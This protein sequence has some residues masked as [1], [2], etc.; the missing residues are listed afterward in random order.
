[1]KQ[2][3]LLLLFLALG[4]SFQLAAQSVPEAFSYQCIMR[5]ANG[6]ALSN[7]TVTLLF[8]I[9]SGAPNG[10]VAYSEKQTVTTNEF[11]LINTGVGLGTPLQGNFSTINWGGGAKYLSASV[12]SSPNVFDE[13]GATQLLS[14][15]YAIY[16]REASIGPPSPGD[17]WGTQTVQT[18]P[19]LSGNGTLASPLSI[20]Q[21]SATTGQVLKW[22]GSKWAPKNDSI[23]GGGSGSGSV[24]QINTG[25]GLTGGP[26]T[27]AGTIALTNTG[28]TPGVYGSATEIPVITVDAQGRV[29]GIFKTIVQPGAIGLNAGTGINVQTNSFNN[30][31][32]T[33]TGDTNA[34]DDITTSSTADGDVSGPFSNLQLKAGVVGSSE[35]ADGAVTSG[36]IA[37]DAV[38]SAKIADNAVGS[39]QIADNAVSTSELATGAVTSTKIDDMGAATGQVLKYNGTNWV[40]GTDISGGGGGGDNWGTQTVVTG[41]ALT[42]QGIAGSPLNL[43]PQGATSGQVL[44]WNGTAWT[45]GTDNTGAATTVSITG[46]TGINVTGT[47][48]NFTIVN[49]GD[50]NAA[51]DLTSASTAGGDISGTFNNLQVKPD[52]I[53]TVELN[54]GAV[55][56][57][58]LAD[59]AVTGAKIA[60]NG[61]TNGQV[62]KWNGSNWTAQ[63]DLQGIA[64]LLG[65]VG[66]DV[67]NIGGNTYNIENTGDIN[68][69]DDL[70]SSSQAGGDISGPFSN[71]QI[72]SLV[73]TNAEIA[74][75]TITGAKIAQNGATSGQVLKW[76]GT[77]WA[78]ANDI[79]GGNGDNWGSQVVVT[80]QSLSGNGTALSPLSVAQ[81]GASTGQVLKWTGLVWAPADDNNTGPDNWG[82]QVIKTDATL[83]GEGTIADPL[84]IAA[85]G[86]SNG[87]VLKFDSGTNSWKPANDNTGG[88]GG[89]GDTYTEGTG[90]DITGSSPNFVVNNTGDLSNSNE[91]QTISL[92][93]NVLTLSDGGGSVTLPSGGGGTGDNYS[94]GT[95]ISITGSS[96]NFT[97]NNTGDADANPGNEIQQL[98]VAGNQLTISGVGGNTVTL[99]GGNTY[100]AGTGISITGSAPNFTIVNT[101]DADK[102][103]TNE[104]QTLD[105]TG[106]TLSISNG[107][108]VD[109]NDLLQSAGL[110]LWKLDGDN[111]YNTN[112]ENVLVGTNSSTSGQLQVVS[113]GAANEA[114]RFT[115]TGGSK[116][117]VFG[118]SEGSGPGGHFTSNSGAALVTDEGNVGIGN[119]SPAFKLDVSGATHIKSTGTQL[120]LEQT[121]TDFARINLKNAGVGEWTLAGKGAGTASEFDLDFVKGA[122]TVHTISAKDVG[123][124]IFGTNSGPA[125]LKVFQDDHGLMLENTNNNHNWEFSVSST[126]GSLDFFYDGSPVGNFSTSGSYTGSDRNLKYDIAA[127]PQTLQKIMQLKPVS[128]RYKKGGPNDASSLGFIAQDVQPLFPELVGR[129]HNYDGKTEF[130]A[131]NY[132]GFGVLAIKAVQEQQQQIESLKKENQD[133]KGQVENLEARL[134]RLEKAML[135][136]KK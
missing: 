46:G 113:D 116:A 33:N 102:N 16:A 121:T 48:P 38:T 34:G 31:T 127:L 43:A 80:N 126:D 74:N 100:T 123:V 4:L 82:T 99:P 24:T 62:L 17:N 112:T 6:N 77:T 58:N 68:P 18:S 91:L 54:D 72:K 64:A 96:P 76:N 47:S 111:I 75:A 13:L 21:Q 28:V 115:V 9:R 1:M 79:G 130:L 103:P 78:A 60:Q 86:A 98:S 66:I 7:Q 136:N 49:T 122:N 101:G 105:L 25:A 134:Q 109:F 133:L 37:N 117:A 65:G 92:A 35:L 110:G 61:A 5:D 88:G 19:V 53:T 55:Q 129:L 69:N 3:L 107:N 56:T 39:D 44:K 132:G 84:K 23:G 12:E 73:V 124:G 81:Q 2:R 120:T 87:Q 70:T 90:I 104:L 27:V 71:L 20:A 32:V 8:A 30:F 45:P 57:D 83:S 67:T 125:R 36:K 10:P 95:G 119:L 51:D 118:E 11:G 50:T 15:P 63:N 26:I 85:Q 114:G 42:G 14:V 22:D 128:Y 89:T 93:G 94:A 108:E 29:T 52:V 59:D 106:S 97:I 41:A 40:P 131:L 135:E